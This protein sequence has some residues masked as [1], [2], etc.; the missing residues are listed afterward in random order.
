MNSKELN[1]ASLA[2]IGD[3]VLELLTRQALLQSGVQNV[4]SLNAMAK[5]YVKATKQSDAVERILPHLTETEES[6]Y[7]RGRN[8][9]GI[10]AP[11]S[12][13]MAQY[14]RATG[15]EALFGFL[16]LEGQNE[17]IATLFSIAFP[18]QS[19]TATL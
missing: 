17:R 6:V 5:H 4:G 10:H 13:S 14:R 7:R 16:F 1:G 8:A 18:P 9:S 3:A 15:L 11:K 2:Y 12:A 19:T